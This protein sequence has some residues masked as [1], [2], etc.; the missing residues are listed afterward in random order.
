MSNI[1]VMKDKDNQMKYDICQTH[2]LRRESGK[3]EKNTNRR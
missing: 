1:E 2:K 3:N